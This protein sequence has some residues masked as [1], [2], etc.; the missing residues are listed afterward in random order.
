ME[1][2]IRNYLEKI[3][4]SLFGSSERLVVREIEKLGLG[5]SNL[6]YLITIGEK[7]YLLRINM[8][9][10]SPFKSKDEYLGLKIVEN[11]QIA[12]VAYHYEAAKHF[13]G[14][15]FIIIDYVYGVSLDKTVTGFKTV[16]ELGKMI[17]RLHSTLLGEL[18]QQLK[19]KRLKELLQET[20]RR[21]DRIIEYRSEKIGN[22]AVTSVLSGIYQKV[23]NT[24]VELILPDQL[25]LGHGDIAPQNVIIREGK[26]VLI[27]WE[28]LGLI[29][30]ALEIAII[31]DSFDYSEEQKALFL[32]NYLEIRND[33]SL[34]DRI[35]MI[36]S[37]QLFSVFCWAINHVIKIKDRKMHESFVKEQNLEE[38]ISYTLKMFE[39][40]KKEGLM[41]ECTWQDIEEL[42]L[43]R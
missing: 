15:K 28:D 40:C 10:S 36:W 17:A 18:R 24:Q 11:L 25:V 14:E 1:S 3:D 13:L 19:K 38:H 27:D 35:G 7:K 20:R 16:T 37:T 22:T 34:V 23:S 21:I 39:K 41:D 4:P 8:D 6:N 33:P 5:E 12:P 43:S 29:D 26:L 42:L 9:P 32:E 31:F 30:P 2:S